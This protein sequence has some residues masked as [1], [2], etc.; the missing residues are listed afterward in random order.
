MRGPDACNCIREWLSRNAAADVGPAPG[1]VNKLRQ[2]L[3]CTARIDRDSSCK[4]TEP[5]VDLEPG[6][7]RMLPWR[8]MVPNCGHRDDPGMTGR[9]LEGVCGS[10]IGRSA[11]HAL[12]HL[13]LARKLQRHRI[14]CPGVATE[15]RGY[16]CTR[17]LESACGKFSRRSTRGF[18]GRQQDAWRMPRRSWGGYPRL[19]LQRLTPCQLLRAP[20]RR[21]GQPAAAR[22]RR[23]FHSSAPSPAESC[24][25]AS[26]RG[27]AWGRQA[28]P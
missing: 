10:R 3:C 24:H 20:L 23:P 2:A 17:S 6:T 27:G 26:E 16:A 12:R 25:P 11:L 15:A 19:R 8:I 7:R 4:T 28:G 9:R 13:R 14:E 22:L 5:H 18:E 1:L 21:A